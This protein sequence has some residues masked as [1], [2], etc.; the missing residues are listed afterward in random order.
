[1]VWFMFID[2]V[3]PLVIAEYCGCFAEARVV[4]S[5]SARKASVAE[6][7]IGLWDLIYWP[8]QPVMGHESAVRLLSQGSIPQA[9]AGA[10]RGTAAGCNVA[11]SFLLFCMPVDSC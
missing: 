1:M 9:S 5:S 3:V 6:T 8:L 11:S 10:K 4:G 2:A 7:D